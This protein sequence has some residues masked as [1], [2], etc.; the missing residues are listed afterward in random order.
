[1]NA[2]HGNG[3]ERVLTLVDGG[4]ARIDRIPLGDL[5]DRRRRRLLVDAVVSVLTDDGIL[6][7]LGERTLG[8]LAPGALLLPDEPIG[9]HRCRARLSSAMRREACVF[10]DFSVVPS[11]TTA[12]ARDTTILDRAKWT[13]PHLSPQSSPPRCDE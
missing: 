12:T 2:A 7:A 6:A 3:S 4:A 1:M 10:V 9:V 13:S 5:H 8:D 11:G